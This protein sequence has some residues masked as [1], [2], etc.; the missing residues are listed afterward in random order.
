MIAALL[1]VSFIVLLLLGVPIAMGLILS[2]AMAIVAAN[3]DSQY[4]SRKA[5]HLTP[6]TSCLK[7]VNA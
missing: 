6:N 5:K 2:A 1:L 7:S 4:S 3:F